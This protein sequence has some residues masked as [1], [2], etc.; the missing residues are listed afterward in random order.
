VAWKITLRLVVQM[1]GLPHDGDRLTIPLVGD[2]VGDGK[3]RPGLYRA[4]ENPNFIFGDFDGS[5]IRSVQFRDA[6]DY[7]PLTGYRTG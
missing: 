6:T 5:T 2:W 3:F 1:L 4:G 7:F